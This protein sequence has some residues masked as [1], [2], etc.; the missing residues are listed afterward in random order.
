M[1]Y[2]KKTPFSVGFETI[3]SF[4]NDN[5]N[6]ILS[7]IQIVNAI[8]VSSY[9]RDLTDMLL[10]LQKTFMFTIKRSNK[11]VIRQRKYHTFD[12]DL[13]S[14]V[15]H[16]TIERRVKEIEERDLN[17]KP[18]IQIEECLL[19]NMNNKTMKVQS[20][21]MNK[22]KASNLLKKYPMSSMQAE[23]I[24][25]TL[26][27]MNNIVENNYNLFKENNHNMLL[28]TGDPGTGKSYCINVIS[29][30]CGIMQINLK[31]LCFMGVAAVNIDG[32]TIQ[33]LFSI[34]SLSDTS[35][36]ITPLN[37]QKLQNLRLALGINGKNKS[38]IIIIDEV[39]TVKPSLFR[40]IDCR[41]R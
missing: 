31:R 15:Y 7:P 40:A 30:L 5:I 19:A 1:F 41:L 32:S 21:K 13:I 34:G 39:S 14:M 17:E 24:N 37:E 26:D 23:V 20:M 9:S 22:K 38:A 12:I 2:E 16:S 29:Q 10:H 28:V 4:I 27:L 6:N 35:S 33:M 36:Y 8:A 3:D 25:F 18:V 11:K